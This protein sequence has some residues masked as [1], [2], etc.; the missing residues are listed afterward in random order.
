[1]SSLSRPTDNEFTLA[2]FNRQDDSAWNARDC[3]A[4]YVFERQVV[5][6]EIWTTT[7]RGVVLSAEDMKTARWVITSPNMSSIPECKLGSREVRIYAD[8]HFGINDRSRHPQ[9]YCAGF[10]YYATIPTRSEDLA[11]LWWTPT[12]QDTLP[13][14]GNSTSIALVKLKPN[15]LLD[16]KR[17]DIDCRCDV[18]ETCVGP[19]YNTL[20]LLLLTHAHQCLERLVWGM[21]LKD[22]IATVADWQRACLD[23][24]GWLNYVNRFQPRI[25]TTKT[26]A[27]PVDVHVMGAFTH[28]VE[29]AQQLF[30]MGIPVYLITCSI[31]IPA[32]INVGTNARQETMVANRHLVRERYTANGPNDDYPPI[33]NGERVLPTSQMQ[34]ALQR[35][36]CNI[37]DLTQ[38]SPVGAVQLAAFQAA[39]ASAPPSATAPSAHAIQTGTGTNRRLDISTLTWIPTDATTSTVYNLA[40]NAIQD[41]AS[42]GPVPQ[43]ELSTPPT[44][45][46]WNEALAQVKI[47]T[48]KHKSNICCGLAIPPPLIFMPNSSNNF[49]FYM[50]AWLAVRVTYIHGITEMA[51]KRL[52]TPSKQQWQNFFVLLKHSFPLENTDIDD[53]DEDSAPLASTSDHPANLGMGPKRKLA[54]TSAP[55]KRHRAGKASS[56]PHTLP[57]SSASLSSSHPPTLQAKRTRKHKPHPYLDT[58]NLRHGKVENLVWADRQILL[59]NQESLNQGLTPDVSCEVLWELHMMGFNL[60][61]LATDQFMAPQRWPKAPGSANSL[62]RLE[63]EQVL[64]RI[65]PKKGD[66]IGEF[67]VSEIPTRDGGLATHGWEERALHVLAFRELLLDWPGC[68]TSISS[69]ADIRSEG[70]LINLERSVI[71]FYCS[72]FAS[73]FSRLPIPPVRLPYVSR[74]RAA[75]AS[76][77]GTIAGLS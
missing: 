45:P 33:L 73:T 70:S 17:V 65:F 23:L 53:E 46:L 10:E 75:P 5:P 31:H 19:K 2:P 34:Q 28:Y 58:L 76:L 18:A 35:I 67:F 25:L 3:K 61:L 6:S 22:T 72:C 38:G 15:I 47:P 13:V 11:R 74:M 68:P 50:G 69:A 71:K 36:G 60:E 29:V 32:R 26:Q 56:T 62:K 27:H 24:H 52:S 4:Y 54:A 66:S 57:S 63:R 12:Q 44:I 8:G 77:V 40:K 1:M 7:T 21:T 30:Q 55:S 9:F 16:M 51:L 48:G 37:P 64:R 14:S 59:T 41:V 20:P 43:P 49:R 39:T 42:A